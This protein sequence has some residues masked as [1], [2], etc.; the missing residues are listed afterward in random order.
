[1]TEPTNHE[2]TPA[3]F[4]WLK[5]EKIAPMSGL[6]ALIGTIAMIGMMVAPGTANQAVGSWLFA[7]IFWTSLTLGFFGL[8]LLHHVVRGSWGLAMLRILE[9]G[10]GWQTLVTMLVLF[11]PVVLNIYGGHGVYEWSHAAVVAKDP[12]LQHKAVYL[13]PLGYAVRLL[14]FFAI[15]GG[16]AWGLRQSTV[17]QD[18]NSQEG[19]AQ[20][21]T[22]WSAP[23]MV[24]FFLTV[25]F[26]LTDWGMSLEPHWF[27][28]IYPLWIA[29]GQAL[30]AFALATLLICVNARKKPFSDVIAP[31]LLKDLGTLLFVLT[32]LWGY[33]S[34]SQ[35]LI[36]WN[37]NIPE[38]TQYFVKRSELWWNAVGA[39]L[40]LG[41]FVI[42]FML[43]LS[44]RTKKSPEKLAKVA[45]WIFVMRFVDI[46]YAVVP[47]IPSE[48]RPWG[49]PIPAITDLLALAAV[50]GIWFVVF[51]RQ[52]AQAPLLPE[53]D[54]RL[55]EAKAHAH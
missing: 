9:A 6:I 10:G 32:M 35:Y 51:A 24:I 19:E 45:G 18:K 4:E 39:T 47:G 30:G 52:I 3:A 25:T 31:G 46:F 44:P 40:I 1:M 27:S 42:P 50:G 12:V 37:G 49:G 22:N 33:T 20:R 21:R 36:I 7:V 54:H 15:W 14:I 23:G 17:R 38:F 34:I 2:A 55:Q 53:Y 29:L 8:T 41:Q 26:A 48:A 5:L 11:V 16:L 13:N 43:L 28:T